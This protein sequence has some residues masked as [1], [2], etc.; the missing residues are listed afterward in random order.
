LSY[1]KKEEIYYLSIKK[2][3]MQANHT[4]NEKLKRLEPTGKKCAFC[5]ENS[6][7][8]MNDCYFVPL[9]NE[10]DRTNII[11]YRSV[12]YAKIDIGLARCSSC[13]QI[14]E[15]AK[16]R[17]FLYAVLIFIGTWGLAYLLFGIIG[18]VF[19]LG[20][21]IVAALISSQF[22]RDRIIT[23]KD[24]FT[25]REGAENDETVRDFIIEGWSFN[26]PA[27]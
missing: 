13:K 2:S 4:F 24:I 25:L 22:F 27:A 16:D 21:A 20:V 11:V 9:Y 6:M 17:A 7:T 18:A 5:A 23:D 14:H 19:G 3:I 15:S 10:K 12:K 1:F 8:S 26:A